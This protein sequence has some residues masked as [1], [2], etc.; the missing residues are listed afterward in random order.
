MQKEVKNIE[1]RRKKNSEKNLFDNVPSIMS[2][3]VPDGLQEHRD[4]LYLGAR[5]YTRSFI[6]TT[7]PSEI[8]LGWID[9]LFNI[10]EISISVLSE[11]AYNGDVIRQLTQKVTS[12]QSEYM[13]YE[14]QGNIYHLPELENMIG[15]Y[16]EIRNLIQTQNDKLFYVTILISLNCK[17]EKELDDKT[18]ILESELSKKSAQLRTLSFRQLDGFKSIIPLNNLKVQG[19]DR[20]LTASGFSALF[21]VANPELSHPNGVYMGTNLF[22]SSP[23]YLNSFIGPPILNN[24]HITIFGIPGSGKSVAIKLLLGRNAILGRKIV[25]LDPEGE[26]Q[27]LIENLGGRYINIKQGYSSGINIFD[28][29]SYYDGHKEYINILDKVSE[30]RALLSTISH[31]YMNRALTPKEL[32]DIEI[33]VNEIYVKKGIT[34]DINSLYENKNGK[35]RN[36]KYAM[37]KIKKNMPT[38]SDFQEALSKRKD[39]KD[40]AEIL[41]PFLKGRSLGM[42]DCQNTI[43]VKEDI[44]GFNLSDIKDEFT[45]FYTTFVLLT[46]L[47]QKFILLNKD[48]EKIVAVDESWMFLKYPESANFLE[49]L[50]RRGRKYNTSLIVASQYLDEYLFSEEGKAI[51]KGC[52]TNIL[53]KQSSGNLSEITD[54]FNLAK[55]TEDFLISARP[56][57]CILN[58]NGNVTAIKFDITDFEKKFVTT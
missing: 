14:E 5:R 37:G 32:S 27:K 21:P 53:M 17:S 41:M 50:A 40:L 54:F 55:G 43:N 47:W 2:F 42:F 35:L 49:T 22:T 57:E 3:L 51:I 6:L 13:V 11:S 4:K 16:E 29:E 56:G 38:F 39:S 45:K 48:K 46:W 31:E 12:L 26:Y 34:K 25:V 33:A 1:K 58:L 52:S 8:Y 19:Y 7:Y 15:D 9:D 18:E 36:G 28:I 23:V 30:M 24:Q 10:G 20:N 44:I